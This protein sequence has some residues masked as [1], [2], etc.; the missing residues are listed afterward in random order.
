MGAWSRIAENI[1]NGY[2]GALEAHAG[3]VGSSGHRSNILKAEYT[4]FGAGIAIAGT[5]TYYVENFYTR[6]GE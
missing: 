3:W 6:M 2:W 1:A 4:R 5:T